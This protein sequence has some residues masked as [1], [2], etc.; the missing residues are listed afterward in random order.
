MID[1]LFPSLSFV[2]YNLRQNNLLV[3]T[4]EL[5][6]SYLQAALRLL[7]LGHFRILFFPGLRTACRS[8]SCTLSRPFFL[9]FGVLQSSAHT[10]EPSLPQ[11]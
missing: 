5:H 4:R 1:G 8:G 3:H 6:K 11:P 7:R 9:T 2:I 10:A